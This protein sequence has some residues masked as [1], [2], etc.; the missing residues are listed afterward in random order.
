DSLGRLVRDTDPAGGFQTLARTPA[1]DGFSVTHATALGRSTT[2]GVERVATGGTRRSV[3]A[4]SGLTVTSTLA[5]DGTTTTT[6]P[7][8]TSTSVVEGADP[9][10]GMRAP[11]TRQVTLTTPGGLTFTATTARRVTLSDPADPLSL[12]SQLDSV[13]VN[14][15]VYTSAYDQAERRF[16]GVSPAGRE[17]FVS[18]DSV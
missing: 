15:R 1:G 3:T 6:T 17:G 5:S 2:Y 13:V 11:L 18:V 16:R 7:D 12:T 4:P 9:R 10:F 8:G 14:G